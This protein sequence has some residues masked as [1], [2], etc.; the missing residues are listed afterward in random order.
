MGVSAA[1]AEPA[2]VHVVR[3][4]P[5]R[6][7][8]H[9]GE[10]PGHVL[11]GIE[12]D[13]GK[14][15]GVLEVSTRAATGNVLIRYD[16]ARTGATALAEACE[17][18]AGRAGVEPDGAE[19]SE[20]PAEVAART[21][22]LI[23]GVL[24]EHAGRFGRARIA[25]R[26]IDSDPRLARRVVEA[27]ERRPDVRRAMASAT[28][29]RVMVEFS[30]RVAS[31]QDLLAELSSLELP[32]TPGEDRPAH[33][34][35]PAPVVQSGTRLV[36]SAFGL[37]AVGIQKLLGG[38][39]TSAP[40]PA[41]AAGAAAGVF[42]LID[43][44]PP[45]RDG[46]RRALG[47]DR[48]QLLLSGGAI[49]SLTFSGSPLGLL[50][51]G[52]GALRLF[53]EARQ[54]RK[55]WE[56]YE[57]RVEGAAHAQP[58]A[59][60]R[61]DAGTR[62]PLEALVLEG[63]G[64]VVGADGLPDGVAP[65][66]RLP[67]GARVLR[68]PLLV[69]LA[70]G[71]SFS[72]EPRPAPA[73][74][75]AMS[76]YLTLLGPVSVG[77]AL[78][79]AFHRRSPA[80]LFTGLLLVNPRAGLIG[81]EA[82]D[83]GASARVLR[84]G[85]TVVGTRPE[86]I[87]RRPDLLLLDGP[88]V[89]TDGL[90]QSRVVP[91]GSVDRTEV[92]ELVAA[93]FAASDAPWGPAGPPARNAAAGEAS[94]DGIG[95][96]A[97]VDG[98]RLRLAPPGDSEADDPEV[99]RACERGEQPLLL[100]PDG[101][102]DIIAYVHLRPRLAGGL[103]ELRSCCRES[104]VEIAV[105]EREDRRAS[106][107]VARRAQLPL[108]LE[109]DLV[110]LV[111]ERQRAGE[112][113]AV[114][115]DTPSAAEAFHACDLAIG[116]SSGRSSHFQAR[117]DLLAPGL[118]AV[119][120]I[121]AA[122]SRRDQAS[123]L[124]VGCSVA[125]NL[126]GAI[127]GL[128]GEPGVLSASRATYM[129]ALAALALG[130]ERLRGGQRARSVISRLTDPR[131]ERWGRA[132]A[133]EVLA[134]MHAREQGLT[135][136]EAAERGESRPRPSTR[137]ALIAGIG[138][139]LESPLMAVLGA[140][141][142][143]SL[144]VGA[145]ADVAMI[146]AVI[147]AN[148]AVGAWQE[149]QAGQATRA[150]HRMAA[151]SA[152]VLR[153]GERAEI[154]AEHV[155]RG[156]I[157]FV[158]PGDR[159]VADARLLA[160]E[161][162]EVD[163]ASLTGESLP[164]AK[165][166]DADAPESRVILEG[167]DVTVG[168]GT[169]V[170]VAVGRS[171]RLGATAAALAVE[172]SSESPLGR[173]LDHLFRQGIPLVV[174]G[175]AIVTLAGIAW[176]GAPLTQL[177]LGASVAVAAVPEGLP[178]LAGVAEA[179]VA[180][181]LAARSALVRRLSSVEALGRVDIACCDKTGTLTRGELAVTLVDDLAS[182]VRVPGE[183]GDGARHVL[184]TAGLASPAPD[185]PD[186]H[187]HPTDLAILT[188]AAAAGL[189]DELLTRREA[190]APFDPVRALHATAT[191]SGL[192]V[193]GAAEVLVGRCTRIVIATG[194]A[195]VLDDDGRE[196]LL[197]RAEG[198]A[199]RGLRVLMVA[200]GRAGAW[201]ED[202]AELTAIGFIGITDPLRPGAADAVRRCRE[203]GIRVVMLTGDHP[204]TARAIA[205]E[206][207][208]PVDAGSV[209]TGDE[210]SALDNGALH[211]RLEHASVIARITPIDKLRIVDALQRAGHTVAM[212][213]D[214]VNDAPALRLADVGV[215]MGAGGTEVARQAADLV[216]ADD[217]LETLTEALLEGRS[218]WRNLHQALGLLLGGNLGEVALMAGT[219]ALGFAPVLGARQVL[220]VNL[221]TDVLPAVAVAVQPPSD[222]ELDKIA[223]E[224]AESFDRRLVRDIVRRGAA[225]ALPA[226]AAVLAAPLLGAAPQTVAFASI[227]I[228]QLA[229]TLRTDQ[230]QGRPSAPVLTAIA[231][232]GALLGASLAAPPLRRFLALPAP[233]PAAL[234]LALAT[235]P[236]AVALADRW[237]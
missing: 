135:S 210:I 74:P 219:A 9:L 145:T 80:A 114:L 236:A 217:R 33:P 143:I 89:L 118:P 102:G 87:I 234:G 119:T 122:G 178:L 125:A 115:S 11:A 138:D 140:G 163:E 153:D 190:E 25:V 199:G 22:H 171:T 103:D 229:Q 41:R 194:K 226:L 101:G 212:T 53:T 91:V 220:A 131:P 8:L 123:H 193:K 2:S 92:G 213:G 57:Q 128:Q 14:H 182:A 7:R 206:A 110:E 28:T 198:L 126:A 62:V 99:R 224:G 94:F 66:A 79:H 34:L 75:D 82:A 13:L 183:L 237:T 60:I 179:S 211:E 136:S 160:S 134:A 18:A 151:A 223:R 228:T 218:L 78:L 168:T 191:P 47:R 73:R 132:S 187:A 106:R 173:R 208:L 71:R 175:G 61:L 19:R 174:A 107:M 231:G 17:R 113:V 72:P 36:G 81:T 156:D 40:V 37:A 200:E 96:A 146:G 202:P 148:A 85:V 4:L 112:R 104:E 95:I 157:L 97:T 29:G 185:S 116:L 27:L 166:P 233:T 222:R 64:T 177:A 5:G 1:L 65:G 44:A 158:G 144:A 49:I 31:L 42:G 154:P 162:L 170:V 90:E 225:T 169:A 76:R 77:Y 15:P 139:Q 55:A 130:W 164:V 133:A 88:R 45:V 12:R 196:R 172:E 149:H 86:R 209:I 67:P 121:I 124:A 50:V 214:G 39:G 100:R 51:T 165:S 117:A 6:L 23:T 84:A 181:R 235:G 32:D 204:A 46:L 109:A 215:A 68:G 21:S 93:M 48:A 167:S 201:V 59:V 58:S 10:R 150:L 176:G 180:R 142:A 43:G 3:A 30:E 227:V 69:E 184:V 161:A 52:A 230:G 159:I 232:S 120:A 189:E 205:A 83:T 188:A 147:L 192:A 155:V 70:A 35:D 24:R 216:I 20:P 108:I 63:V 54:R 26:G 141:A 127:S 203:A 111:R 207:D 152:R 137:N 197:T 186:A 56:E 38:A 105:L 195:E 221:V 98:R 129:G 16:P